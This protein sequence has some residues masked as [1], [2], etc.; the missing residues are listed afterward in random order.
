MT[1]RLPDTMSF[2]IHED[3]GHSWLQ[4]ERQLLRELG[5]EEKV[6]SY[7]YQ[8]GAIVYLEEDCDADLL[9]QALKARGVV[10]TTDSKH[11]NEDSFVRSLRSYQA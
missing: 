1:N 7:S 10:V 2:T 8:K 9:L 3:P 11:T 4:C 5:I 6:S